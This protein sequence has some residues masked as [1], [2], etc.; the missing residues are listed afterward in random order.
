MSKEDFKNF[1]RNNPTLVKHVNN[2][3]VTWQQLY[4]MYNLYGENSEVW[5]DYLVKGNTSNISKVTPANEKAFKELV[6]MIKKVDLEK[7]RHGIE[8]VQKTISLIQDLGV[9]NKNNVQEQYQNRPVYQHF[10]D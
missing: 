5:D 8:G 10:D 6:S 4:E 9:G 2:N 1:V 7:V 3:E